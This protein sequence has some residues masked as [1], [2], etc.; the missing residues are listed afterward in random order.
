MLQSGHAKAFHTLVV[1]PD[2]SVI[3]TADGVS[4]D[5]NVKLWQAS[6]GRQLRTLVGHAKGVVTLTFSPDGKLIAS[7]NDDDT[8]HL[9]DVL[10]GREVRRFYVPSEGVGELLFSSDGHYLVSLPL[11]PPGYGRD[12]EPEDADP[13][14]QKCPNVTGK[15]GFCESHDVSVWDVR[16]GRFLYSISPPRNNAAD[17]T[18]GGWYVAPSP[19]GRVLATTAG[20]KPITLRELATGRE[21][22]SPA[23]A[24]APIVFDPTGHVIAARV[25][26]GPAALWDAASLRRTGS[27]GVGTVPMAFTR[28]GRQ[29]V[30]RE[31]IGVEIMLRVWDVA[32][33]IQLRTLKLGREY[34]CA[35]C[36]LTISP[37]ASWVVRGGFDEPNLA[38]WSLKNSD[39]RPRLWSDLR[40]PIAFSQRSDR[41]FATYNRNIWSL[42]M[43]SGTQSCS[44]AQ[45]VA[46]TSAV[47][48]RV[49]PVERTPQW[50]AT[51]SGGDIALWDL[52]SGLQTAMFGGQ[53]QQVTALAFSSPTS[54][55][56]GTTPSNRAVTWLPRMRFAGE[57]V[58]AVPNWVQPSCIPDAGSEARVAT[59]VAPSGTALWD[60]A[61]VQPLPSPGDI[62]A[63]LVVAPNGEWIASS[64]ASHAWI[65]VWSAV[66]GDQIQALDGSDTTQLHSSSDHIS[67]LAVSAGGDRLASS[68][69]EG[70]AISVWNMKTR[71]RMATLPG[72]SRGV[73]A[74]AF[75]PI[76]G[77]LASAGWSRSV[78]V[79]QP[80]RGVQLAT[81]TVTAAAV[82]LA[83]R[84]DGARLAAAI[85]D[86]VIEYDSLGGEVQRYTGHANNVT[87]LSYSSDGTL[88]LTGSDDGTTRVWD[89]TS[90]ATLATLVSFRGGNDWLVVAPD[91][92]FD[93]ST[94]AWKQIL[95]RFG[96]N[97]FDVMPVEPFFMD[98][99]HPGLL[100]EI[101]AGKRP[102]AQ[103]DLGALDRRQATVKIKVANAAT[104]AIGAVDRYRDVTLVVRE[105]AR[106]RQHAAGSGVRDV[107]LFRNG[108]LVR[109]WRGGI[110]LDTQGVATLVAP[111]VAVVAGENHFTAYAFTRAN[112]KSVDAEVRLTRKDS[113]GRKGVAYI[114][115]VGI[116]AYADPKLN[117]T[118]ADSDA[119]DFGLTLKAVQQ[120]LGAYSDVRVITL[121]DA[122]ATKQNVLDALARLAGT[123]PA[124]PGRVA[125]QV[126][127]RL[128]P[129]QPED[130]VFVYFAGHGAAPGAASKRFYL[131][132]HEFQLSRGSSGARPRPDATIAGAINDLE[133][134]SALE[135]V[136]AG[137][138]VLV[139]DACQSGA[140]LDADDPRQGPMNSQGLAQLAYEKGMYILAAAQSD[141]A[142]RELGRLGH[143]LLTYALVED[144]LKQGRAD[145]AP[146]DGQIL[147]REWLDYATQRVP[148][149]Q[150][151]GMQNMGKRGVSVSILTGEEMRSVLERSLQRPRVFYRRE[152]E[153]HGL[154]IAKP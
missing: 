112:I 86:E 140:T 90:G 109:V 78:V 110:T 2:D 32:T 99:Y 83:Y 141:Q 72:D 133:L 15:P 97:T 16:G 118:Y 40:A 96:N 30:T 128:Q 145:D 37:D 79:S 45:P 57:V 65:R 74:M 131:I 93:G 87:A 17:R 8:I 115:A 139:I 101:L 144:G 31:D 153:E 77:A 105:A 126:L 68:P 24:I 18:P 152:R 127:Q 52:Q 39:T 19:D 22:P 67:A 81:W 6:T 117:L 33:R 116:N 26:G 21:L 12:R 5:G 3:A 143:G 151:E 130:V 92:L 123:I 56:S 100:A 108:T 89:A 75:N 27:L 104:A 124:M 20:D 44:F 11:L 61:Q 54:L 142:A 51:A 7:G 53:S 85:G 36:F 43:S 125:P 136:D 23:D 64:S 94:A 114:L 95:W 10:S 102:K 120:K 84:P 107:R 41:V 134:E 1:S 58:T 46:S 138:I 80:T 88:L 82:V 50:L 149:L 121:K 42:A 111:R 70:S 55:A 66:T 38:L 106:D 146:H 148:L 29:L 28:D 103:T 48:L 76:N 98:F 47:A 59:K 135:R 132:L 73:A 35:N 71:T 119:D 91:G 34:E 113:L 63:P 14:R 147:L 69:S 25:R 129:A 137:Q 49:T 122:D 150:R 154:V 62:R 4:G 13:L 9:W 60:V